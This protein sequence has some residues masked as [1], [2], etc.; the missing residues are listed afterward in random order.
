MVRQNKYADN[1]DV[2]RYPYVYNMLIK[3]PGCFN[4]DHYKTLNALPFEDSRSL[5]DHF[6]KYGQFDGQGFR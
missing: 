3:G 6:V 1:D 5:W 2:Y 4:F